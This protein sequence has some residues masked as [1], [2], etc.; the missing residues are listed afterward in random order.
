MRKT[1]LKRDNEV[2]KRMCQ[3]GT[4]L[5]VCRHLGITPAQLGV[6]V[7]RAQIWAESGDLSD[8]DALVVE[9]ALRRRSENGLRSVEARFNALFEAS[10]EAVMVVNAMTGKIRLAN[11]NAA[12]L[13]ATPMNDSRVCL[14]KS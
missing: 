11:E 1:I 4:D 14:L 13:L 10:P 6:I 9:R 12:V 5:E 2:L 8:I 3:G 7:A